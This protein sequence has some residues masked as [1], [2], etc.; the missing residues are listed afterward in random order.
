[1]S[2]PL[3]QR[4]NSIVSS[5]EELPT[6]PENFPGRPKSSASGIGEPVCKKVL[7]WEGV[8]TYVVSLGCLILAICV[9]AVN[10]L[11]AFLGQTNQLVVVG[12]LLSVM[13]FCTAKVIQ[14]LL[15]HLEARFSK[16]LLQNYDAI[17]TGNKLSRHT[18]HWVRGLLIISA[19]LPLGLSASYKQF[20][21]GVTKIK[22]GSNTGQ[23]YGIT[24]PPGVFRGLGLSLMANATIPLIGDF[25]NPRETSNLGGTSPPNPIEGTA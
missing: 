2:V 21:G 22:L 17:L 18:D 7:I 16:S 6:E 19:V 14:L 1:M 11:A 9:V 5:D 4:R 3:I 13:G 12:L 15:I 23:N 20:V 8:G 24:G 25:A 10:N